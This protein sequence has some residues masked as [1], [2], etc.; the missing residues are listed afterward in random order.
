MAPLV[1]YVAVD[2]VNKAVVLACR[3]SL[4]LSDILTDLTCDYE[5]ISVHGGGPTQSY[6]VHSGMLASAIRLKDEKSTIHETLRKALERHPDYGLVLTGHSLGGGVAALLAILWGCPVN[7]FQQQLAQKPSPIVHPPLTT[8]F[9][10]SLSSGLPAGRPIHAYAYGVPAIGSADLSKYGQGLVTSL[11]HGHDLVP[12]LSL[13]TLRDMLHVAETLGDERESTMAQE[14]VGAVVGL[15]Q[16]KR[17]AAAT[18][19]GPLSKDDINFPRP[20]EPPASEREV[21]ADQSEI[22]QGKTKNRALEAGYTD[23]VLKEDM[24][25]SNAGQVVDAESN[26][27]DWL[28]SLV[29]T[30]RASMGEEKLYPPGDVFCIE[31]FD[32]YV[33]PRTSQSESSSASGQEGRTGSSSSE[34][35]RVILRQCVDVEKRFSEPVFARSM[36]RDHIPTNCESNDASRC[37]ARLIFSLYLCTQ[38]SFA[39]SCSS[40]ACSVTALRAAMTMTT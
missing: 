21:Q 27:K 10:T 39:P 9:V 13:G 34:A 25:T 22:S 20:S 14:I 12:S 23:P 32:C 2:D 18:Q 8:Q 15:Y 1:N 37:C 35:H 29:K 36:L 33:T 7:V 16:R 6:Y 11:V 19:R 17:K 4:G 3:G 24:I 26:T 30:M 5:P 31:S 38:M 40:R 28:W